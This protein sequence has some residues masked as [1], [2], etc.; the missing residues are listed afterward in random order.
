[1]V[2]ERPTT[3]TRLLAIALAA[4]SLVWLATA[5][6]WAGLSAAAKCEALKNKEAGKYALCLEK[7]Q[8][9]LVKTKGACSATTSTTC[10][11]DDEC[12]MGETCS[13]DTTKYDQLVG[14]CDQKLS[15]HWAKW[16]LKAGGN[17]PTNG[18]EASVQ[19]Q[20]TTDANRTAWQLS[21]QARFADNGDGTVT[22]KQTGLMWEKKVA[23]DSTQDFPNL[24]DADNY[25]EWAGYCSSNAS[26]YCQPNT[27]AAAT[28]AAG[29]QGDPTG[30][31]ECT[32]GDGT[33]TVGGSGTTIWDWLNQLNTADFAGYHDWRGGPGSGDQSST[34]RLRPWAA[35]K[36]DR[37]GRAHWRAHESAAF[38]TDTSGKRQP[39][40]GGWSFGEAQEL[41]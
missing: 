12:P 18:D 8:M 29:V 17:C 36:A 28:C 1:M 23:P 21:G 15:D 30:C 9:K 2:S 35:G 3:T 22:D 33:C 7:A 4:T 39:E 31:E 13:K 19:A 32:G 20:L 41:R 6:A 25:Y 40:W 27:A 16:E 10:Y 5:P 24:Q 37:L 11:R 34:R 26:E 38:I 14:K